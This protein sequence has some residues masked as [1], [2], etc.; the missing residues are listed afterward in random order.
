MILKSFVGIILIISVKCLFDNT[1]Y[2]KAYSDV[3]DLYKKIIQNGKISLILIYSESC[4]HCRRFEPDFIK[5]SEKYNSE[6]DFYILSS[7]T[8]YNKKFTIRGYPTMFFYDGKEFIEHKGRN[9]F[10]TISYILE[11]DYSKKCIEIDLDNFI[12]INKRF[13]EKYEQNYIFGY[14]PKEII[15]QNQEENQDMQKLISEK[16]FQNFINNTH[17]IISLIDNC[18]YIRNLNNKEQISQYFGEFEEGT[19]LTFSENKGINKFTEYRNLLVSNKDE[20]NSY[21]NNRIKDI[22]ELYKKFL[23]EKIIDYYIDITDSKMANKLKMFAK[24]N[25]LLFVYNNEQEKNDFIKKINI[26]IGMT[27]NEK[28]P[29]FDYV[30]FKYGCNLFTL[31][32]YIRDIGIYYVD[33]DLNKISKKIDLNLVI[34]MINTQNEYE[35]IP[36]IISDEEKMDMKNQTENKT[37]NISEQN[38]E[39]N[40][41]EKLRENIIEKQLINYLNN[42]KN[43]DL[44]DLKK[45]I[46]V[47]FF[48]LILIIYTLLFDFIYRIFYPEK[49]VFHIF[50]DFIVC[51]KI[52]CCDYEEEDDID[53]SLFK[54]KN[55]K[56]IKIYDDNDENS[57]HIIKI[58]SN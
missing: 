5:L 9:N 56:E 41:Y 37:N 31:S 52:A 10:E 18:Y 48:L 19:I 53:N 1:K 24:R 51:L 38:K 35:Y 7:K 44:I 17:Q 32:Y 11:N 54:E 28:Y 33:K 13:E 15:I 12:N 47:V 8:N 58:N 2:I 26:L 34:S 27:K 46:S 42:K 50:N 14:F 55:K 40:Y 21:Y 39:E 36:D 16:S 57:P 43:E 20:D 23:K 30:L 49:S 4:P 25:I 22:G 3:N 29:L 6:F 45:S